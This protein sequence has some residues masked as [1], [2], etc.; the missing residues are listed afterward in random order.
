MK[1]KFEIKKL[2]VA[3]LLLTSVNGVFAKSDATMQARLLNETLTIIIER[4]SDSNFDEAMVSANRDIEALTSSPEEQKLIKEFL[5]QIQNIPPNKRQMRIIAQYAAK[6]FNQV[7][8]IMFIIM[9]RLMP[10]MRI[11][12]S[13]SERLN[14]WID[15]YKDDINN[16]NEQY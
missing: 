6:T 4:V 8:N 13:N 14:T 2:L 12:K 11:L 10:H 3:V 9:Q 16:N 7:Q 5:L 1:F 15:S